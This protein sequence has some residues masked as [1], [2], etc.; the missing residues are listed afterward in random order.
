MRAMI[1]AAGLGKRMQPLTADLPKPLL[2]VGSKTLI[3][4]QI[5]RLVAGGVTGIVINHFYLGGMI[6]ELL[7]NGSRY[8]TSISYSKEAIRL[9]TA[10]GIIKALP[11]LQDDCFLVVNADIWTDFNFASLEPV[12]G[13]DRL[14]HL[15]LVENADH[16]PHGDFYIDEK[17]RVHEDHSS[18]DQRLTFSGISVMHK[19]LFRDYPI[20]PRSHVPLLQE[21]MLVE[22]VSGEVYEGLW[23]D[24][25]TPARLK[26]VNALR[27]ADMKANPETGE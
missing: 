4:H 24:I 6:E 18:R 10:G 2:K 22:Q 9:E 5:E 7:G 17:G 20:Q 27:D 25:G 19:N 23:M 16:H 13:I 12:D 11:Q 8:G 26:E 21:A 15:V 3:E 1:L 14:A